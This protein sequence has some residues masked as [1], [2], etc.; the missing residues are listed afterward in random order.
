MCFNYPHNRLPVAFPDHNFQIK[1][2][3][4]HN[5]WCRRCSDSVVHKHNRIPF[6]LDTHYLLLYLFFAKRYI[7]LY[8]CL[9]PV[10]HFQAEP[11]SE[12]SFLDYCLEY[13]IRYLLLKYRAQVLIDPRVHAG[14]GKVAP[15]AGRTEKYQPL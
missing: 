10:L 3:V 12:S 1:Y 8:S 13:L 6:L 14:I 15:N 9:K 11:L 7:S 4:P 5:F 2:R